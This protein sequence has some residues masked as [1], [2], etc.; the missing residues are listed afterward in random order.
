MASEHEEE[1]AAS[2]SAQEVSE[3]AV[4]G[5]PAWHLYKAGLEQKGYF[6]V[7]GCLQWH[8]DASNLPEAKM[9]CV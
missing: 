5:M 8:S 1:A 2:S 7:G 3:R 6:K 4:S 9:C